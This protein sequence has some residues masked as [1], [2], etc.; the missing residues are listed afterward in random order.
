MLHWLFARRYLF[1][2]K[3]HSVINIIAAV[4]IVAIAV[5]V[6]AM[7]ILLSVFNGFETLVRSMS[8][9]FDADLTVT[10]ATGGSFPTERIDIHA[11]QNTEGIAAAAF[12][13]QQ[14]VLASFGDRHATV[15]LKGVDDSW[16]GVVPLAETVTAGRAEVQRGDLDFAL[17]GQGIAYDLG[18]RSLSD[19]DIEFYALGRNGFSSVIPVGNYRRE[20]LAAAGIFTLDAQTDGRYVLTSLRAAQRLFSYQGRA[21]SVDI[22]LLPGYD[23]SRTARRVAA[24]LG[25]DFRVKTRA[26]KNAT[27][28][29][30]MRAEKRSIFLISLMVLIVASFAVAGAL[31]MLTVEKRDERPALTALGADRAFIRRIFV[32]EG[33]LMCGIGAVAGAIIGTALC[34]IQQRYGLITIP[35]ESFVTADYPVE[36]RAADALAVI[37]AVTVIS[38]AV[39]RITV[40]AMI[41]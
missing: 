35:A 16:F 18:I 14:S 32:S 9:S 30:I 29:G 7:I 27:I 8:S 21:T 10:A 23:A 13:V 41:K 28:Y 19:A 40:R 1:S 24:A 26:E 39:C 34:L 25:D 5:P 37:A 12:A 15:E 31:A 3:S 36:L 22:S 6:A 20:R 38:Q 17:A 2:R 33:T 4:S 11:L